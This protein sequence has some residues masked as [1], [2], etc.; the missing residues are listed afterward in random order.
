MRLCRFAQL[1]GNKALTMQS[2]R[3]HSQTLRPQALVCGLRYIYWTSSSS[4]ALSPDQ[5]CPDQEVLA[6]L[7]YHLAGLQLIFFVSVPLLQDEN[8]IRGS[9]RTVH[10]VSEDGKPFTVTN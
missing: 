3:L 8:A 5:D 9:V 10:T 2:W 7:S 6:I 1:V 4:S